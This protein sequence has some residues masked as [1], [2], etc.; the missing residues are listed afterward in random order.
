MTVRWTR[1]AENDLFDQCGHI[2]KSDPPLAIRLGGDIL[3]LVEGLRD[4][5]LR[6]RPGRVE[7]TREL[8]LSGLP[9]IVV[10]A[11]VDGRVVILRLLHGAQAYPPP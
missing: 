1:R 10:Y 7:G 4:F 9:W 6:G 8:V 11:V 2:A 3:S 5:P